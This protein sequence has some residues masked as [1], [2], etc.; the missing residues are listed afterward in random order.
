M[1]MTDR[2]T[3]RHVNPRHTIVSGRA[4]EYTQGQAACGYHVYDFGPGGV[5]DST[6]YY[7]GTLELNKARTADDQIDLGLAV[8]IVQRHPLAVLKL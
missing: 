7:R 8:T 3:D 2:H 1:C 6:V 4:A 5:H